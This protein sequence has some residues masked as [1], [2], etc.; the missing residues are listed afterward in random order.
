MSTKFPVRDGDGNIIALG[1]VNTNITERVA[2]E[3]ALRESEERFRSVIENSP[4]ALSL[5]DM[6]GRFRLVNP[7][8]TEWFGLQPEEVIGKTAHDISQTQA[9]DESVAL[10]QKVIETGQTHE[11]EFDFL[12]PDGTLHCWPSQSSPFLARTTA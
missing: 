5:K 10:D 11:H 7:K 6:E 12:F 9:S 1:V 3:Q 2:T 8:F 4:A